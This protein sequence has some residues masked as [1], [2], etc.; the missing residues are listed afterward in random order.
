MI[1]EI[2]I[3]ISKVNA[4]AVEGRT[5]G[6]SSITRRRRHEYALKA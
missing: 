6:A 2:A 1:G 4:V 5:N 3:R